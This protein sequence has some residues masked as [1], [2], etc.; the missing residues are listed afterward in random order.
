MSSSASISS[1][2][3]KDT[4][5]KDA[6]AAAS[7]PVDVEKQPAEPTPDQ[8]EYVTGLKLWIMMSGV[9]LVCFV[10]LLDMSIVSTVRGLISPP[11]YCLMLTAAPGHTEDHQ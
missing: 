6:A 11:R 4:H 10:M 3:Q 9:T 7:Q 5:E 1:D 8:P 2:V